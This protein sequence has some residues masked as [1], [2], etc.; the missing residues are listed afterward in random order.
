MKASLE[1]AIRLPVV[2][3]IQNCPRTYTAIRS[4]YFHIIGINYISS[5]R[6][7]GWVHIGKWTCYWMNFQKLVTCNQ[8]YITNH[9][10]ESLDV[11]SSQLNRV[12][13]CGIK[14]T[15]QGGLELKRL[16]QLQMHTS[17]LRLKPLDSIMSSSNLVLLNK[18]LN[19]N[20]KHMLLSLIP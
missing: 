20:V 11:Y 10:K 8:S 3:I 12:V 16:G 19:N 5:Q 13:L 1:S 6:P 15:H 17:Y 7:P 4:T 14:L 18:T 9:T 2:W